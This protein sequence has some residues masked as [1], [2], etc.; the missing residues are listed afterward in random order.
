M[1]YRIRAS[2]KALEVYLYD[3]IGGW[4]GGITPQRLADD[5]KAAGKVDTINVRINSPG[6][7]VFD[8]ITIFNQLRRH[9]AKVMVDVDG[10]AASIASVIAM[11]GDTVRMADN[12]MF[13]IHDPMSGQFGT[14][15][16]LRKQADLLDQVRDNLLDTYFGKTGGDRAQI[17][18][19]MA[20]ETWMT[21][22]QAKQHGFIDEV[23]Q[24]LQMAACFDLSR[25]HNAP[26][27]LKK[28]AAPPANAFRAK[29]AAMD[30]RRR[31]TEKL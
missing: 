11:A 13:M 10:L 6:G 5:L 24:E 20:A 1:N 30:H 16:E 21:A 23:T 12:A 7:D 3:Y 25:Y 14:A 26:E 31:A 8:G 18:E 22:S 28:A 19:L 2:G 17:S 29:L 15:E 27:A 9:P 4:L